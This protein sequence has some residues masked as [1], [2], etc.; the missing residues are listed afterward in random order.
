MKA[1]S[2]MIVD[3]DEVDRYLL[4][5]ALNKLDLTLTFSEAENGVD[6]LNFLN[7]YEKGKELHGDDF[8]P[9]LIFLDINMPLMGGFE[10]LEAFEKLKQQ[11]SRYSSSIFTM[12]TSS[13]KEEDKQRAAKYDFVKG[14]LVKGEVTTENLLAVFEK[15]LAS[16]S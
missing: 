14:F 2:V 1:Y 16:Q 7:D 4:I 3:D 8:P 15:H 12:F 5:R 10:F 13:E 9:I 11:D 6:A